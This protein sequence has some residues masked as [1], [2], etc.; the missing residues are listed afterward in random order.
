MAGVV[1]NGPLPGIAW[2][3]WSDGMASSSFLWAGEMLTPRFFCR[4]ESL[5]LLM[6]AMLC[7]FASKS[8]KRHYPILYSNRDVASSPSKCFVI[9]DHWE[10]IQNELADAIN[11]VNTNCTWESLQRKWK[12]RLSILKCNIAS[13]VLHSS[14]T[15]QECYSLPSLSLC[16]L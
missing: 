7:H 6:Q 8:E 10:Q 9:L 3:L 12:K 16:S 11:Y 5:A 13:L 4:M 15:F 1:P 14:G 2:L